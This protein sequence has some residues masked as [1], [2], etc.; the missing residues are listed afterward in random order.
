LEAKEAGVVWE[1]AM[2]ELF[3]DLYLNF[4]LVVYFMHKWL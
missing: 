1:T 3:T 2:A 4:E